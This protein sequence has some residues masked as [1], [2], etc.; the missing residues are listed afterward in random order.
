MGILSRAQATEAILSGRVWVDGRIERR[1]SALVIPERARVQVD[2]VRRSKAGWRALILH[3]PRGVLTTRRD[4][5]G[6]PTVYDVL[7]EAGHGLNAVGR[8]DFASSGLLLF[9][10]DTQFA[11]W[12]L[13]PVNQVPR[14]YLV[15][16]RG[17]LGPAEAANL[18]KGVGAGANRIRATA[19]R[20]LKL[21]GRESLLSVE[22]REGRNRE[23][24]RLF[25]A[26]GHEVTRLKRIQFGGLELK[27]LAPGEW[28][29][30]GRSELRKAFPG[31]P[32]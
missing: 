21:S 25:D 7:D 11:N 4:P 14:T 13:D 17:E 6:R 29:E 24:R 23:I 10:T 15:N 2:G 27:Q 8:L 18:L 26:I 30:L 32:I 22:L 28:R 5:D 19:V 1:P 16:V 9:T 31:A 12:I 20:L 3:K